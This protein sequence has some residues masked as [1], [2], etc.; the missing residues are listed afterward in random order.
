MCARL[1]PEDHRGMSRMTGMV[2][3]VTGASKGLGRA[4]AAAYARE[5]ASLVLCAR[6]QA[7]LEAAAAECRGLGAEVMAVVADI[8][9]AADRERLVSGA[10]DRFGRVDVLVNNASTLGPVPLPLLADIDP[11]A[12]DEVVRVDLVAPFLL[13]RAVMGAML[14]H[15]FGVLINVSSDA[16][17]EAYPGWGAYSAAKAGLDGLTRVWAAELA[18]SGVRAV[19]IDPGDMDTEMHRAA[20]PDDDPAGLARPKDVAEAFVRLVVAEADGVRHRATELMEVAR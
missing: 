11:D 19:S 2:A 14:V 4:V 9:V 15:G 13:A 17:V 7:G 3:L 6:G 5:G 1:D 18:G 12:F 10:L 20:L 8:A 16:A